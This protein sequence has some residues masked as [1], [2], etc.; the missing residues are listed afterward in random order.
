[1]PT[2]A[3][4]E[5]IRIFVGTWDFVGAAI[6]L[7]G[8]AAARGWWDMTFR[9]ELPYYYLF[10]AVLALVIGVTFAIERRRFGF[11]LHAIRSSERAARSL[12]VPVRQVKL[13]ALALS[14]VFTS[15]AGS[16][17]AIKTGFIDPDSGFGIL[18]SVQMVI[19]AALGGAG[20][21]FGPLIGALVLVPLQ[22]VTNNWLGGGGSGLTYILYGGIIMVIARFEPGGLVE[23]WRR[24]GPRLWRRAHAA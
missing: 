13:R 14:A 21:L 19:V 10:L 12:G 3:V 17:Y 2:L 15:L 6:G 1:M 16:L 20:T 22:T 9:S 4:A 23:L 8:P 11:Y 18:V 24:V 7:Q 5:L